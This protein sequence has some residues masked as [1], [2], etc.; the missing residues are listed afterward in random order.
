VVLLQ[1]AVDTEYIHLL[2]LAQIKRLQLP[3]L[4]R[5]TEQPPLFLTLRCISMVAAAERVT[6]FLGVVGPRALVE[7]F[8]VELS[9]Q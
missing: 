1:L 2:T 5:Q 4:L 7:D 3:R 6:Q 8:L 9:H